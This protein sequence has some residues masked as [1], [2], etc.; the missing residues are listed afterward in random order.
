MIIGCGSSSSK[1][2]L[3][4]SRVKG[5]Q[6]ISVQK[7][8][9]AAILIST[10]S[11][12]SLSKHR[13]NLGL[14]PNNSIEMAS[15]KAS[16]LIKQ[17]IVWKNESNLWQPGQRKNRQ[18]YK[19]AGKIDGIYQNIQKDDVECREQ[20]S[21]EHCNLKES[22]V[23]GI[24]MDVSHYLSKW[25]V[26][27]LAMQQASKT[28]EETH[29]YKKLIEGTIKQVEEQVIRYENEKY[30]LTNYMDGT[31]GVYRWNYVYRGKNWGYNPYELSYAYLFSLLGYLNKD[32]NKLRKSYTHILENINKYHRINPNSKTELLVRLSLKNSEKKPLLSCLDNNQYEGCEERYTFNQRIKPELERAFTGNLANKTASYYF[33]VGQHH[34]VMQYAFEHNIK[35]WKQ[36]YY[37]HFSRFV[38]EVV[39]TNNEWIN[40][41]DYYESHYI[42]WA[43][44]FLQLSTQHDKENYSTYNSYDKETEEK[45]RI[46]LED[47]V[48]KLYGQYKD[49]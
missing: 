20:S 12:S 6:E 47:Y 30:L 8:I 19:Y 35:E 37:Q 2:E 33:I 36:A 26:F 31:N 39:D 43:S 44:I 40:L 23:E 11:A 1:E 28:P 42:L 22:I 32:D 25:P 13:K 46:F 4:S 17:A 34:T 29:Y 24:G 3:S 16:Q 7:D 5:I 41:N 45:L 38:A 14:S 9:G 27:F 49:F 10:V 15:I 48:I 18:D 21:L